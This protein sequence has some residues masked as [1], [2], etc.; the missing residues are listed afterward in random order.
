M[1]KELATT[2]YITWNIVILSGI[3]RLLK[4]ALLG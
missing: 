1:L 3:K 4:L 2:I